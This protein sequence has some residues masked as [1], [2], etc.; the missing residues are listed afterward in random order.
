MSHYVWLLDQF[1]PS[2]P[3]TAVAIALY[4]KPHQ[5]TT[6][7]PHTTNHLHSILYLC[8]L[9]N[10]ESLAGIQLKHR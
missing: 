9:L 4:A 3:I 1:Y 5:S 2:S 7:P 10:D 8:L 6:P